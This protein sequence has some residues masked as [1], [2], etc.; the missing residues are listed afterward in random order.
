MV[1]QCETEL[2]LKS[3]TQNIYIFKYATNQKHLALKFWTRN[4]N[5]TA[6]IYISTS[7]GF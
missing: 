6:N 7:T 3:L 2:R 5:M 1:E 4:I